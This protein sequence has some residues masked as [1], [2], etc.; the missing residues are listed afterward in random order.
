MKWIGLAAAALLVAG[1]FM[2]WVVI[3]SRNI[4]VSGMDATGTNYGRP[5]YFHLFFTGLFLCF[6]LIPTLWAKR[7]NLPVVALNV[8]WAIR[9][10]L[11]IATC[12]AGECPIR[13]PGMYAVLAGSLV[14]LLAALFP[15]IDLKKLK[16]SD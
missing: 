2:P 1:C 7:F 16:K 10:Y 3:E 12:Q 8:A 6:H 15:D 5:G 14:M 9:N 11:V 4:T 13:K